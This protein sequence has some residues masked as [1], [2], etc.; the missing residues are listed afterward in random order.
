LHGPK[1]GKPELEGRLVGVNFASW[2]KRC[3]HHCS[4]CQRWTISFET[5]LMYEMHVHT[6]VNEKL[7][8]LCEALDT[9]F[10]LEWWRKS[11]IYAWYF[12]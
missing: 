3:T 12:L 10:R 5:H 11:R 6:D 9:Q 4:W 7:T 2:H 8:Y 1:P